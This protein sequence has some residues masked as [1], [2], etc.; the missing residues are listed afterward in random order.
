MTKTGT[1]GARR[2]ATSTHTEE[3]L[4]EEHLRP[5]MERTGTKRF[6]QDNATCHT[7]K[8][9]RAWFKEN[10]DIE[11]IDWPPQSADMNPIENAWDLLKY[12]MGKLPT[13]TSREQLKDHAGLGRPG[14]EGGRPQEPLRQHAKEDPGSG[15]CGGWQY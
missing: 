15:G 12:K 4:L 5:S 9:M 8:S 3:H 2:D 10:N 6:V 14:R 13:A 11:V 1:R 7:A